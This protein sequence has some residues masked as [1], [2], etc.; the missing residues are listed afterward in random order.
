MTTLNTIIQHQPYSNLHL[1]HLTNNISS[2]KSI[3]LLHPLKGTNISKSFVPHCTPKNS[4]PNN[5][6]YK[7]SKWLYTSMKNQNVQEFIEVI[8]DDRRG[9]RYDPFTLF[10]IKSLLKQQCS[11]VLS[12]LMVFIANHLEVVVK[13]ITTGGVPDIGL[14]WNFEWSN[15]YIP[16]GPACSLYT[17]H[18][19]T[20]K[21]LLRNGK[22]LIAPLLPLELLKKKM[23]EVVIPI[24]GKIST[25][26]VFKGKRKSAL[27]TCLLAILFMV[28]SVI[29][30]KNTL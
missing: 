6:L 4:E 14:K 8:G 2:P 25:A 20:G 15:N 9:F 3:T 11:I 23:K 19:Y 22:A 29:L 26:T 13:P 12:S 5:G 28:I 27:L 10:I 21:I 24:F 17:T 18:M 1:K 7:A 16:L 30:W